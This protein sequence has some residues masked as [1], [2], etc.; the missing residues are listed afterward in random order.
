MELTDRQK[1]DRIDKNSAMYIVEMMVIDDTLSMTL[2]SAT[3]RMFNTVL[4]HLPT[5]L[6]YAYDQGYNIKNEHD[7]HTYAVT[8]ALMKAEDDMQQTTQQ[9]LVDMPTGHLTPDQKRTYNK[10][11]QAL[12]QIS[13]RCHFPRYI[14]L[15]QREIIFV[16]ELEL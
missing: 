2:F 7:L 10:L 9:L 15:V 1:F 6:K 5:V 14:N 16:R 4:L 11:R 8:K 13:T 12:L 3:K